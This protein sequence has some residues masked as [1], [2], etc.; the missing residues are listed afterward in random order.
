MIEIGHLG[1]IHIDK[2]D[3]FNINI[4]LE[5]EFVTVELTSDKN[6]RKLNT[7]LSDKFSSEEITIEH[8]TLHRL[9]EEVYK[10]GYRRA[11]YDSADDAAGADI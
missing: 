11:S 6:D 1:D 10:L 3:E 7:K 5:G 9:I 2:D 8:I 4:E